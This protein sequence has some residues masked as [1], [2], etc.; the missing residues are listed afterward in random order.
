VEEAQQLDAVED[1]LAQRAELFGAVLLQVPGVAGLVRAGRREGEHV[2]GGD[3]DRPARTQHAE[4]V[5]EHS[6]GI[7]HVLDRLE[8]DDR[9]AGLVVALDQVAHEADARPG[10]LEPCVLVRLGVGV[11]AGHAPGAARQDVYAVALAAGHVDH[12]AAGAAL[13]DP[14]VHREVAA[15]PV[16]LGGHVGKRPLARQLER[17]DALGLGSLDRLLH[18][19]RQCRY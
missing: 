9:V 12:V 18:G 17:R 16:V 19:R 13:G 2:R 11:H 15:E 14:L 1:A 8:E 3:V 7:G 6:P 5:A 4:E 10:V